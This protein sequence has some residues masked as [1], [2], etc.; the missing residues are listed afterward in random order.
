MAEDDRQGG[1][2]PGAGEPASGRVGD[3]EPGS[4]PPGPSPA[5]HKPGRGKRRGPGRAAGLHYS[6]EQRRQLVEAYAKSG[7]SML[8]FCAT[9][10]M[11]TRTLCIWR[12]RYAEEGPRGLET[13]VRG[14]SKG[15]GAGSRLPE[16]V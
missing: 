14:P 7:L 2:E 8:D 12:K 5:E 13:R 11:S 16:P 15:A 9:V 3:P 10:G 6:A 1:G 4:P